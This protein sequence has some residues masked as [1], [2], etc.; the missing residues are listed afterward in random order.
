MIAIEDKI[1]ALEPRLDGLREIAGIPGIVVGVL[2]KGNVIYKGNLGYQDVEKKIKPRS[3]TLFSLNSIT[4]S[5]LTAS[6]ATLVNSGKAS[7]TEP[8]RTYLPEYAKGCDGYDQSITALDILSQRTGRTTINHFV[9]QGHGTLL[10][11]KDDTVQIWNK[12][13]RLVNPRHS[14]SYNPTGAGIMAIVIEKI[15]NMPWNEFIQKTLFDPLQLERT[16]IKKDMSTMDN[17]TRAY[18]VLDDLTPTLIP[19]PCTCRDSF[20]LGASGVLTNI[21]EMLLIF[22]NYMFAFKDQIK[23]K[24]SSTLDNPFKECTTI[25]TAHTLF[26]NIGKSADRFLESDQAYTTGFVRATLPCAFLCQN[27]NKQYLGAESMPQVLEGTIPRQVFY[28]PGRYVGSMSMFTMIPESDTIIA[29]M[30]NANGLCDPTDYITQVILEEL[31]DAPI[32]HDYEN[33]AKKVAKARLD[34]YPSAKRNLEENRKASTKPSFP[35][36]TYA[37]SFRCT[38]FDFCINILFNKTE[39]SLS[40]RFQGKEI[41]T[42][43]LRYYHDDKFEWLMSHNEAAFAARRE[44]QQPASF[45]IFEFQGKD[46]FIWNEGE[47]ETGYYTFERI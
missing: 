27:H 16:H 22:K 33:L 46:Q 18:A 19:D 45:Y 20:E 25:F 37:G 38:A 17:Y 6:F 3:D 21:D 40:L 9:Y 10:F 7:W 23:N 28:H 29:V 36:E 2:H 24:T 4:K 44:W 31:F 5:L 34:D 14:Y 12:L 13:S 43:P 47:N 11:N 42:W 8:I 26:N 30:A 32:R 39:D 41:E 1:C 15:T 35:L